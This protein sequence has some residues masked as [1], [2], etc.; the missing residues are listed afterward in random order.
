MIRMSHVA[1]D[2]LCDMATIC[3]E[4]VNYTLPRC[5]DRTHF[6]LTFHSILSSS[7]G[8]L[9]LYVFTTI[10]AFTP[11]ILF[12]LLFGYFRYNINMAILDELKPKLRRNSV[13][14][15]HPWTSEQLTAGLLY[16]KEIHGR[17]PTAH[18]VDAFDFLPSSRS[19]QRS[20]GGLV[21][22]RKTL[23]PDET[24]DFTRGDY[25][26]KM[27]HHRIKNSQELEAG[28]YMMLIKHFAEIAVHEHKIIR[29]GNVSS[30]F[31]VYKTE[32]SGVVIDIFYADSIRNLASIIN[33][34]IKRYILVTQP[35]YLIVVGNSE[36]TQHDID[37]KMQ[38]RK[39]PLPSH[40][41][42]VSE[43]F[44]IEKTIPYLRDKSEYAL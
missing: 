25:R 15:Q 12:W 31:F 33:T 40:I 38:N 20:Y 21:H 5:F 44:F 23:I 24:S 29:P 8:F 9:H 36:I 14:Y 10:F 28:F 18:D 39:E 37:L 7:P 30:D 19:I 43:N 34:K 4:V 6:N 35:T 41:Q 3:G 22:L 16:F 13:G 1:K 42:V 27:A 17:F 32:K 26:S 2:T 11:G